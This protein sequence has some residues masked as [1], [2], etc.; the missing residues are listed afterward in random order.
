M[1]QKR[2]IDK[3]PMDLT[4]KNANIASPVPGYR[5][6]EFRTFTV[7]DKKRQEVVGAR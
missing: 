5:E 2:K 1:R 7:V 3:P 6:P 4:L